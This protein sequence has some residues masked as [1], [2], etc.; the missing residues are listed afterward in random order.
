M[1]P[2]F[3][4]L[5]ALLA[6]PAVATALTSHG[7]GGAGRVHGAAFHPADPDVIV[8]APDPYGISRTDDGGQSWYMWNKGLAN[9]RDSSFF[10]MRIGPLGA[11]SMKTSLRIRCIH[12]NPFL[13]PLFRY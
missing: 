5:V 4:I 1:N 9:I 3:G 13:D 10:A 12:A 6:M 11:R 2:T 7:S 8:I